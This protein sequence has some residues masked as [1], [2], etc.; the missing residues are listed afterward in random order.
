M[1]VFLEGRTFFITYE[2]LN[3]LKLF[4]QASLGVTTS[5][6]NEFV[7]VIHILYRCAQKCPAARVV[8]AKN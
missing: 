2:Y 6:E 1:S 4:F 5:L 7:R 8:V 3:R